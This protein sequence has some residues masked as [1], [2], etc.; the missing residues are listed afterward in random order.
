MDTPLSF[1]STIPANQPAARRGCI[2]VI[3]A[4]KKA[5]MADGIFDP[6][7]NDPRNARPPVSKTNLKSL[8]EC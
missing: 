6:A 5:V 4:T 7:S 3:G 8:L 1:A 2:A